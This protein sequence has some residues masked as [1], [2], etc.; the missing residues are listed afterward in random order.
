MRQ[1]EIYMRGDEFPIYAYCSKQD[2]EVL[3]SKIG[4]HFIFD[5]DTPWGDKVYFSCRDI[6]AIY[7]GNEDDEDSE[8]IVT[9]DGIYLIK[10]DG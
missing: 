3:T 1:I 7:L 4:D 8:G 5:L 6:T 10:D 9:H 2:F